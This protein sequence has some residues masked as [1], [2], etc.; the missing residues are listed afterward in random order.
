[1]SVREVRKIR[2]VSSAVLGL[3]QVQNSRIAK[4]DKNFL[5]TFNL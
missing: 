5:S 4:D 3:V 1:V 2:M